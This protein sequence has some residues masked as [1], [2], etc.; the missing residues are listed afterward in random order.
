MQS[1]L[2]K[3]KCRLGYPF[4]A[5]SNNSRRSKYSQYHYGRSDPE[6]DKYIVPYNLRLLLC[7]HGHLN[8]LKVSNN[9][10]ISYLSKYI[11]KA[12][13]SVNEKMYD[14][15]NEVERYF[16]MRIVSHMEAVDR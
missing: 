2:S 10:W 4:D 12:E 11:S 8:V 14:R 1:T 7:W 6:E 15:L 16:A 5:N 13:G 3:K 9:S